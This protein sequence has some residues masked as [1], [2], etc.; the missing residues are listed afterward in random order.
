MPPLQHNQKNASSVGIDTADIQA[1][2][3]DWDLTWPDMKTALVQQKKWETLQKWSSARKALGQHALP[4]TSL[5]DL[6]AAMQPVMDVAATCAK[7]ASMPSFR[8]LQHLLGAPIGTCSATAPEASLSVAETLRAAVEAVEAAW[9][10]SKQD[11]VKRELWKELSDVNENLDLLR[12]AQTESQRQEAADGIQDPA[13]LKN[14]MA[15][16]QQLQATAQFVGV[17]EL[18]RAIAALQTH[19]PCDETK[20]GAAKRRRIEE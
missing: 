13:G 18:Q 9:S 1:F 20:E 3:S 14:M 7:L 19:V 6:Q 4:G 5:V 12:K 10:I 11:L 17:G 8:A 16:M 2:A 15:S